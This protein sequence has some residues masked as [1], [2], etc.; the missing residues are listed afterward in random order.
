[1]VH[2]IEDEGETVQASGQGSNENEMQSFA[3][4][5][6]FIEDAWRKPKYIFLKFTLLFLMEHFIFLVPLIDL[7]MGITNRY[8]K[9]R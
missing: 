3:N 7:K 8:D 5:A 1:M 6:L 4:E 2:G 9:K